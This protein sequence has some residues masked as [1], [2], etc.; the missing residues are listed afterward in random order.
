[1]VTDTLLRLSATQLSAAARSVWAKSWPNPAPDGVIEKWLPLYQH[2]A[3]TAAVAGHIWDHWLAPPAK[4]T[5]IQPVGSEAAARALVVWLAGCHDVGKASPAFAVQ[6]RQL[7]FEMTQ[8]GLRMDATLAGSVERRQARHELV[9]HL[10]VTDWLTAHD[11]TPS[12]ARKLGSVLA[13]HHGRPASELEAKQARAQSRLLGDA[14]WQSVR[15]ELLESVTTDTATASDIAT[16]RTADIPQHVL[17][18]LSAVVIVA[19]WIASD[20][21]LFELNDLG[22]L[23][24]T[25]ART[26][27]TSALARL[28]LPSPWTAK[29]PADDHELFRE[30][31]AI[32]TPRPVQAEM[33]HLA[34][35]CDAP[36]LMILEA[37]MGIGKT[38]AALA[39]AEILATRFDM[40][41]V[42][43]GLPT[44]A[45]A[46]G[47]F[48]RA[49]EW[50]KHLGLETPIN[51]HLGHSK[52]AHNEIF[53]RM[54]RDAR[55]RSIG[56]DYGRASRTA[57]RDQTSELIVAHHW[58]GNAK[59]GPLA[60]LVVGTI[61]QSLMGALR[62]KHLMLRHL[63][64]A[65]KVVILD[66]VHA[67]D[68][69]MNQYLE[70]ILHWLAV[71][72]VPVIMLSA[73]LPA[74]RRQAFAKAYES[75]R[76]VTAARIAPRRGLAA[77]RAVTATSLENHDR[78]S[79]LDGDI[80]YPSIVMTATDKTPHVINPPSV[81]GHRS[82]A[83]ERLDDDL[84][85]LAATLDES[86]CDG[87]TAVVIRNT[88]RRVQ[89][90]ADH[91]RA[92]TDIPVVVAHSR[93]LARDRAEKDRLL[94]RLFG[95][96]GTERPERMIIVASQVVEQSLDIDFDLMVSDLAPIDLL[97]Q[98]VGRLHRHRR[99]TRPERLRSPR[100]LI[101]GVDWSETPPLPARGSKAVY[102][103]YLLL[104][105]LAVLDDRG[106]LT[107]PDEIPFLVQSVYGQ[108]RLG[109]ATWQCAIDNARATFQSEQMAKVAKADVF[110]LPLISR[111]PETTLMGW[112]NGSAGDPATDTFAQA[113]VRDGEET[114]EVLVLQK[115]ATGTLRTPSWLSGD[116][117]DIQIP[118][119]EPPDAALT[120]I[121]LGCSLRLPAGLCRGR[122]IDS[123]IRELEE[124]YPVAAWHG[125]HALRGELVLILDEN[126]CTQIGEFQLHYDQD[127]GLDYWRTESARAESE[128]H[129]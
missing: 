19:D 26:R 63:A 42:F 49:I 1:M 7:A 99:T 36:G 64:L 105:T 27:A 126:G 35:E 76:K 108:E 18:L 14:A 70:R 111:H 81:G 10:A 33:M 115:D 122:G 48:A 21:N 74:E 60:N 12:Q 17:V 101:A 78:F 113:A 123:L 82:I 94:L 3:D 55:F 88:V 120:R 98:R 43:I 89:E 22:M 102:G 124:L 6:V 58:F 45:T 107:L 86:L 38:E 56:N 114:L 128:R 116:A 20:E 51:V 112:V 54:T 32:M 44:Q 30:R 66:E 61:D 129:S 46:D 119:N 84:T 50:A 73:T 83:L 29:A 68:A 85:I 67:Y 121:I 110:R 117:A 97:L 5:I 109:P 92:H 34:R 103:Q 39:A 100:L 95:K 23:P 47:M 69:F 9:S 65:S 15:D 13:A 87:G 80:G 31:F 96:V 59:R 11:F 104:R 75:G 93:F 79:V 91:L 72:G 4:R 71:Y 53:G 52:S 25:P 127:D 24:H 37:E 16:W 77:R 106:T 62:S 118:D 8:C 41:G 28:D 40:S 2:L 57:K 125:S 90:T